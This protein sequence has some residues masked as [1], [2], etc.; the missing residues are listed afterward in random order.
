MYKRI[1][2]PLDGS[3]H[4]ERSIP[5]AAHIARATDGTVV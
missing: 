5:V 2:V 3:A 4:A 1:L